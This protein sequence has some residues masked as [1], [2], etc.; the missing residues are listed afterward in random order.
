M[1]SQIAI[2]FEPEAAPFGRA[3]AASGFPSILHSTDIILAPI[4]RLP[5]NFNEEGENQV[6]FGPEYLQVEQPLLGH[7]KG[8][9]TS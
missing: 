5:S 1:D 2:V 4:I 9:N 3:F 7:A 6:L 8:K